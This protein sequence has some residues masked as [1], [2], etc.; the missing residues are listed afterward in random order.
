MKALDQIP[1]KQRQCSHWGSRNIINTKRKLGLGV[2]KKRKKPPGE[3]ISSQEQLADELHKPIKRNFTRRH[4]IV[5]NIDEM[6]TSDLIDMQ[7]L[8]KFNKGF[9]YLLMV[10]DVFSKYGWIKPLKNKSRN[11]VTEAFE[12]ILKEGRK[13]EYLWTD[14]GIEFYNKDLKKLLDKHK[15]NLYSTENEQKSSVVERWNK[16][17]KNKM[18]KMFTT[19]NNSV[20]YDK[21]DNLVN[22][23]NTTKQSHIKMT[24]TEASNKKNQGTVYFNLHGNLKLLA[25]KP[26][27]KIGDKVRI[28]KYKRKTFDK[29]YTPN[30]TEET[31]TVDKIQYTNPIT[32]KIKDLNNEEIKG[33]FYE[34][35]LLKAEK[36]VF[37]IEK[38]RETT[39]RN[40][41]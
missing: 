16:K 15:I 27:C 40:R 30:W 22:Q 2:V 41:L 17:M 38:V 11:S 14:K 23:Y 7:L 28:S 9:K 18:W 37:R 25:T 26:K 32:C 12:T 21:L 34:P 13:P 6:W 39:K 29:G 35:E 4:V 8:A 19:K 31:F 36:D 24:P 1:Y 5:N 20:Y 33:S 3:K 10:I